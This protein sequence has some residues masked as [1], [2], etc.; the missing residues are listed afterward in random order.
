[1]EGLDFMQAY[2]SQFFYNSAEFLIN[3]FVLGATGFGSIFGAVPVLVGGL[4]PVE[5]IF[6][7]NY[8]SQVAAPLLILLHTYGSDGPNQDD[9]FKMK[10]VAAANGMIY[11]YP[12][13]I[14]DYDKKRYWK[15]TDA[16]CDYLNLG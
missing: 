6:P 13:G 16:C 4:R 3:L 15:G 8:N 10:S 2:T 12:N 1:M 9:Y 5:V 7:S 14:V 11:L